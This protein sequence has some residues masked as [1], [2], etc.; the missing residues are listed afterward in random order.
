MILSQYP[1]NVDSADDTQGPDH[2]A[3]LDEYWDALGRESA[4]E[5][6]EQ[7]I[8]SDRSGE[9]IA[10]D[11][12]VLKKLYQAGCPT[13]ADGEL[14]QLAAAWLAES[15]AMAAHSRSD[16]TEAEAALPGMEGQAPVDE[17]ERI[18]KFKVVEMLDSGGQAQVFRVIHPGLAHE[19]VLKLA[20]RPIAMES[21]ECRDAL[22]REGRLLAQCKHPNMVRVIDMDVHEGRRFVVMEYVKGRTLQQFVAQ[23]RPGPR[24]AARLVMELTRAVA[25]LH[26]RGIVHQDIKPRN[27]LMDDR[28]R[29][30]LIDLGLARQ[31]HAWCDD[32]KDWTGG[33][34]GYMSPEQATGRADL[35]GPRTDVFGLGGLLYHLLTGRAL[36]VGT[37]SASARRHAREADHSPVRQLNPRVPRSLE[38]ICHKALEKDPERRYATAL[39]LGRDLRW[40]LLRRWIGAAALF[41]VLLFTAAAMSKLGRGQQPTTSGMA[42]GPASASALPSPVLL[43]V[44]ALAGE[45]SGERVDGYSLL[46]RIGHFSHV[47]R[48]VADDCVSVTGKLNTP[49]Y[50]YVIALTPDGK[51]HLYWPPEESDLPGRLGEFGSDEKSFPLTH[52]S[53]LHAFV[54]LASQQPLPPFKDWMGTDGLGQHWKPVGAGLVHCAW[55]YREGDFGPISGAT[56]G[57]GEKRGDSPLRPFRDVCEHLEKL[58]GIQAIRAIAFSVAPKK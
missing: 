7:L 36:Y 16:G 13:P 33:T 23:E 22:Q 49:G 29:P 15:K 1:D 14:S 43:K 50:C 2:C 20:R 56:R 30:R 32:A 58:P 6:R 24:E 19:C 44:D 3:L 5:L 11:L 40:S 8:G 17:P 46:G 48:I 37:L 18:G 21:Q 38:R 47:E 53:G 28:G 55:E 25:Y 35:V 42:A 52:G 27:V 45:H 10:G 4:V 12:D 41:P 51:S 26:D 57:H 39:A 54:V 9:A 31:N 34:A